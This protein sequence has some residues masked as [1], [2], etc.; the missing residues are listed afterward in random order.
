MKICIPITD[1][2]G[3]DSTSHPNFEQAENYM[4]VD[5]IQHTLSTLS[6]RKVLSC[7]STKPMQALTDHDINAVICDKIRLSAAIMLKRNHIT[8]Y[9]TPSATVSKLLENFKTNTIPEYDFNAVA[10]IP[11]GVCGSCNKV[12]SCSGKCD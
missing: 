8:L 5:S 3:W 2:K 4:L 11:M 10:G 1:D 12:D 6:S 9:S 7:G